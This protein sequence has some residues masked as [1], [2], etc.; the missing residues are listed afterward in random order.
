MGQLI[1]KAQIYDGIG[2]SWYSNGPSNNMTL[3]SNT[4]E[5]ECAISFHTMGQHYE[6]HFNKI[7]K[8]IEQSLPD[9]VIVERLDL[10]Y[11]HTP[12]EYTSGHSRSIYHGYY[13]F[14]FE[15]DTSFVLFGLHF[16]DLITI[17]KIKWLIDAIPWFGVDKENIYVSSS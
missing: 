16:A 3:P 14:F 2:A 11:Q 12:S 13:R 6:S 7:R 10:L 8:Y 9:T 5:Y 15:S 17:V 1:T 4:F